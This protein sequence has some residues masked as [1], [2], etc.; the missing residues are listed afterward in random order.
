MHRK[1]CNEHF[2]RT[3]VDSSVSLRSMRCRFPVSDY[4]KE[5]FHHG[6]ATPQWTCA[7]GASTVRN[8]DNGNDNTGASRLITLATRST[9]D[10]TFS[11]TQ[12]LL[13]LF[14]YLANGLVQ[15]PFRLNWRL[16]RKKR[17][18]F[19][20]NKKTLL[21]NVFTRAFNTENNMKNLLS[22]MSQSP[23]RAHIGKER[24]TIVVTHLNLYFIINSDTL[25][26]AVKARKCD[27]R[28]GK[29]I[30]FQRRNEIVGATAACVR[31]LYLRVSIHSSHYTRL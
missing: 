13:R 28:K 27:L 1:N 21:S 17:N 10:P 3:A 2:H 11:G 26:P 16:L 5:M 22:F 6:L 29:R 9:L 24:Q 31:A 23:L 20:C 7:M 4:S 18:L 8:G 19:A 12:N 15:C 25:A 14:H 30:P